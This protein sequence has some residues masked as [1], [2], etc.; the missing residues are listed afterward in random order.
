MVCLLVV[1][2][3]NGAQTSVLPVYKPSAVGT[4]IHFKA[5]TLC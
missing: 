3:L 1:A 5:S 4:G 2:V